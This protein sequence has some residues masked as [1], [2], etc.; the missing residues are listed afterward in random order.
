[1]RNQKKKKEKKKK[2]M[3][4]N[5]D[6]GAAPRVKKAHINGALCAI[7]THFTIILFLDF[8][9]LPVYQKAKWY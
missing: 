7:S 9:Y 8:R 2:P 5:S 1:M 4:V 6:H 3:C